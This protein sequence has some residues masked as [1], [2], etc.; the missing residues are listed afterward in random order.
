MPIPQS[1][2]SLHVWPGEGPVWRGRAVFVLWERPEPSRAPGQVDSTNG[3]HL[4][5][6]FKALRLSGSAFHSPDLC[7]AKV[8]ARCSALQVLMHIHTVS[9]LPSKEVRWSRAWRENSTVLRHVGTY[10]SKSGQAPEVQASIHMPEKDRV[11]LFAC[12]KQ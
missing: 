10:A 7:L 1:L 8:S 12:W 4:Q 3:C 2:L 11:L 5:H 9:A 6:G